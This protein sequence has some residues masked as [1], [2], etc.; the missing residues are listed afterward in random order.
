MG[1]KE[2]GH[3]A[4]KQR[5]EEII[6]A[7]H[8]GYTSIFHYAR[9]S[10]DV[11]GISFPGHLRAIFIWTDISLKISKR[12]IDENFRDGSKA[13]WGRKSFNEVRN[14]KEL[15]RRGQWYP[16][17]FVEGAMWGRCSFDHTKTHEEVSE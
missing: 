15:W 7:S 5:I 2:Y 4:L 14:S 3:E 12:K 6:S 16:P 13:A 10:T 11:A 8:E 9:P 1:K 17:L